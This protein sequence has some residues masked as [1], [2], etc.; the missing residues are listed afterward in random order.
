[1]ELGQASCKLASRHDGGP[2]P[3][4][5]LSFSPLLAIPS[6]SDSCSCSPRSHTPT[7]QSQTSSSIQ[8]DNPKMQL[9]SFTLLSGALALLISIAYAGGDGD[10][11]SVALAAIPGCAQ[12]CYLHGAPTIGCDGLDFACQCGK[13]AAMFAAIEGCVAAACAEAEFPAVI[14]GAAQGEHFPLAFPCRRRTETLTYPVP[15]CECASPAAVVRTVAVSGTVVP[16]PA[17]S[18]I[19]GTVVPGT[20]VPQPT[21]GSGSGS[22]GGSPTKSSPTYFATSS[23]VSRAE[24]HAVS[25][26]GGFFL[27][28]ATVALMVL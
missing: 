24:H 21:S 4:Y 10:C 25:G 13:Q 15:V 26:M 8:T 27:T 11:L 28:A 3:G 17:A 9:P 12:E 7:K 22:G 6:L 19:P 2:H 20:V 1:M 18:N 23:V 16:L 5:L 14:D